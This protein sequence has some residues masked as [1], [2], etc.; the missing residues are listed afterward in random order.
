MFPPVIQRAIDTDKMTVEEA[1]QAGYRP[2]GDVSVHQGIESRRATIE[3]VAARQVTGPHII[4]APSG[5]REGTK[6]GTRDYE[7]ELLMLLRQIDPG[8]PWER[9]KKVFADRDFRPD[10]FVRASK[11]AVEVDG[12]I[13]RVKEKALR[14]YQKRQYMQ[15]QGWYVV[16][17]ANEQIKNA[18]WQMAQMVVRLLR[19]WEGK[20]DNTHV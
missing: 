14:D 7:A 11:F 9:N 19:E 6:N 1:L 13:H 2:V 8:V 10:L 12:G 17:I 20:N 16:A 4:N 3:A 5:A 15:L 18:G